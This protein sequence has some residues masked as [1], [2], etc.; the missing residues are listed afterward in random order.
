M[1]EKI[2][3][4][5]DGKFQLVRL[6]D[7]Y[8]FECQEVYIRRDRNT[9]DVFLSCKPMSWEEFLS[10]DVSG[11]VPEDFMTEADRRQGVHDRDPFPMDLLIASHAI[12]IGATLV[13]SDAAFGFYPAGLRLEDWSK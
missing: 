2:K 3:L 1:S 13:S 5:I 6:P 7:A 10:E 9:G 8:R 12:A 11:V 4:L